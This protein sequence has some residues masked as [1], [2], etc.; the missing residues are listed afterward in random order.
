MTKR[1]KFWLWAIGIFLLLGAFIPR[2]EAPTTIDNGVK[3]PIVNESGPL[4]QP[5]KPVADL[6]LL[7]GWDWKIGKYGNKLIAG[8]V[9]NNTTR[10]YRY[11]QITFKLYD[12]SGA[13]VGTALANINSLE[14][15]GT[16][17]FEA[18]VLTDNATTAS[19]DS[20]TG[21]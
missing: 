14:A 15:N 19:L 7:T 4:P 10:Q 6:E 5:T 17:K 3:G 18:A 11:A 21:F 9:H 8:E 13:Q 20:L 16:W 2:D 12:D 1:K